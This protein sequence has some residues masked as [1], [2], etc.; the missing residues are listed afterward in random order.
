MIKTQIMNL[1]YV[2]DERAHLTV[3]ALGEGNSC[4]QEVCQAKESG[5][6]L[7]PPKRSHHRIKYDSSALPK[8]RLHSTFHTTLRFEQGLKLLSEYIL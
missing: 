7:L 2:L 8:S 6:Q 3:E 5:A 4:P 1:R